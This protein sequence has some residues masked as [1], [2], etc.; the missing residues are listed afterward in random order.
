MMKFLCKVWLSSVLVISSGIALFAAG[1]E[2]EASALLREALEASSKAS[3]TAETMV[4]YYSATTRKCTFYRNYTNDGILLRLDIEK[5]LF[6]D[7]Y[8]LNT[9]SGQFGVAKGYV[10]RMAEIP[11]LWTLELTHYAISPEEFETATYILETDHYYNGRNCYKLTMQFSKQRSLISPEEF[12]APELY[13][14][15]RKAMRDKAV[16]RRIFIIDRD[17][18]VIY[19]RKHY[20]SAGKEI[21]AVE[22]GNVKFSLPNSEFFELP[23]SE[24][25]FVP[26]PENFY[27]K[28]NE[29][30]EKQAGHWWESIKQ[31]LRRLS[32]A[33]ILFHSVFSYIL[34]ILGI[35][36][37]IGIFI[38]KFFR[39]RCQ[40]RE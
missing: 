9:P 20:N 11:L 24:S 38:F 15:F 30:Q 39:K 16:S 2:L 19:S 3:F 37:L 18:L 27:N 5:G 32:V 10:G 6:R 23:A 26:W 13:T 21:F 33:D 28:L 40:G 29:L 12:S 31:F 35:A 17:K 4:R 8:Y 22:L 7:E 34:A 36:L 14:Q 25:F 1:E